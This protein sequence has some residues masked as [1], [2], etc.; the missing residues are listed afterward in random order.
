MR[1]RTHHRN[2]G[3][4]ERA[5]TRTEL[6]DAKKVRFGAGLLLSHS[7]AYTSWIQTVE[8]YFRIKK[9]NRHSSWKLH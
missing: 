7:V 5:R 6:E 1:A 3:V 4:A 8:S 2:V 9:S